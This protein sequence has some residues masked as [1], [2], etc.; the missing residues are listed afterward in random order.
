MTEYNV[1]WDPV[2]TLLRRLCHPKRGFAANSKGLRVW[3]SGLILTPPTR[4]LAIPCLCHS[5]TNAA[6]FLCSDLQVEFLIA[7]SS[8]AQKKAWPSKKTVC[9][10]FL[11]SQY[12]CCLWAAGKDKV[13]GMKNSGTAVGR[14]LAHEA[15]RA[16]AKLLSFS[17][18]KIVI[19]VFRSG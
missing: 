19:M 18:C 11:F 13:T 14:L 12:C 1:Y 17:I 7:R 10:K 8:R 2:Q 15:S 16:E 3:S 4:K 5:P 6:C 9:I